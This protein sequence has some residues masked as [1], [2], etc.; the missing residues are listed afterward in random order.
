M[1]S[2]APVSAPQEGIREPSWYRQITPYQ[3]KT[4]L[5]ASLGW[6]L[7]SMD[8]LL[9]AMILAHLM[10]ALEMNT[11][12]AGLL[13]SLTLATSAVGGVVF[14]VIADRW[15]RTRAM[16]LSIAGYSVFTAACGL[17]QNVL[18]LAIFR[19]LL[20]FGMGGEWASGAALIAESWP[21]QHRGKALGIMQSCWAVGYALAA[22]VTALVLPTFGWRAVFFV[23]VLPALLILWIRS[24]VQ[25]PPLWKVHR[26]ESSGPGAASLIFGPRL[27][28]ST[29][30]M[31]CVSSGAM[32]AW[33]GLFSW[34][35]AYL[36]LPRQN[37]GAGLNIVNTSLWI[38]IMQVGMWAGSFVFGFIS[39]RLGRKPTYLGYLVGAALIVPIYANTV[40]PVWL[41]LIG[42]F[43]AFFGQGHFSGMGPMTAELFPTKIRA[44]AQG[45]VYNFG[46]GVSALGPYT[47]GHLA[48]DFGFGIAFYITAGSFLF[49]AIAAAFLPETRGIELD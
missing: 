34:V 13:A 28:R 38:I 32:F 17:S 23:G 21:A 41:L 26:K 10:R 1:S 12:T 3:K 8:V 40:T 30:L 27:R 42:P 22:G 39:D 7:D 47:V 24:R 44:T 9:Y 37:G 35:P 33:W 48:K 19:A 15:G 20:G 49:A 29:L 36:A 14:G 43:L 4:L 2:H 45:F 25:E 16:M 11:A 6:T 5:A 18:Q 46:R 31:M